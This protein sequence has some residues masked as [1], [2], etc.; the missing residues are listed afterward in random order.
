MSKQFYDNL[1]R[2]A[3]SLWIIITVSLCVGL[4]LNAFRE[5]PLSLIHQSKTQRLQLAVSMISRTQV[6][7]PLRALPTNLS[8]EQVQQI[9][10]E[11]HCLVLDARPELFYRLG[12]LPGAFSLPRE[13]FEAGYRKLSARIEANK[14]IAIVVY[15][16]GISCEDSRL[17]QEAFR[18]LGY[19]NVAVFA[20]GWDEWTGAD[21]PEEK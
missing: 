12:H 4:L 7:P 18:K 11:K 8:L 9:V 1:L 14:N 17:V 3:T 6:A 16:S 19:T 10:E 15:C 21:L 2:D 5:K 20:G 13:D